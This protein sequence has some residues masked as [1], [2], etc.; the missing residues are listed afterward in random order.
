MKVYKV[1]DPIS[2]SYVQCDTKQVAHDVIASMALN[3]WLEHCHNQP[4]SVVE[5]LE[6]GMTIW[7]NP[8]GDNIPNPEEIK[9][10]FL[11]H[12]EK[13]YSSSEEQ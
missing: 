3:Y 9:K 4:Y 1:F 2:G 10:I 13:R 11:E 12:L 5:I 7:R 6:D 8:E